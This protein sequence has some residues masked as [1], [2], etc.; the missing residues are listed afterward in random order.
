[1]TVPLDSRRVAAPRR[2][3]LA[4]AAA[5][6]VLGAGLLA[7]LPAHAASFAE[8]FAAARD[9]DAQYKASGYD[10]QSA[11]LAVPV[12]R[13][14]LLPQVGMSYSRS[15]VS[16]T[17]SFYNTLNQEVQVQLQYASPQTNL[18]VRMPLWN[19]EARARYDQ[20][21]VQADAAE[22]VYR[23]RGLEL[24]D[25]VGTS[26]LQVLQA[27]DNRGLAQSQLVAVQGQLDRAEQRFKRG[28]GTR[29]DAAL[30][31]AAV[32]IAKAKV[33]EA[34]D[35]ILL[36][37]RTLRRLTGRDTPEL[38]QPAADFKPGELLPNRLT[39]W[40]ETAERNSP[41]IQARQQAVMAA[42]LGVKRQQAGH[43]PRVDL[44]ASIARNE[45]ETLNNLGQT[46]VLK[47]MGVQ[48]NVPLY[49]GGGVDASVKQAVADQSRTEEELRLERE[50]VQVEVQ[51]NFQTV[52]TG[53]EKIEAYR[54]AVTSSEVAVTGAVRSQAAG[55]ATTSDVL[56]AQARLYSAQRDL[57]QTRYDYLLAKL[58]LMAMSG[59][60]VDDIVA[61]VDRSLTVRVS[62]NP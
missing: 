10:L 45:N 29:T 47:T 16:G 37:R 62:S 1:M 25:R 3:R 18:Q 39:E 58:R 49:S 21:Q 12:A 23:S 20:S 28:E 7:L 35:Q 54:R 61:E 14:A 34:D 36:A 2:S 13:S 59:L 41:T 40:F 31:Q 56:D 24:L 4:N 32:D 57:A 51:R 15:D 60:M 38:N 52:S 9:Y 26:Y 43:M 27:L 33:L 53:P 48:V 17:R 22:Q 42:R 44:Y 6:T 30:A 8:I 19:Q 11:K 5:V 46:S 50:S 55:L